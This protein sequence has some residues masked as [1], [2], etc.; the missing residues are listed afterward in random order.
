MCGAM[1]LL[2]HRSQMGRGWRSYSLVRGLVAVVRTA[3]NYRRALHPVL[4]SVRGKKNVAERGWRYKPAF[5]V[6]WYC[7]TER[8]ATGNEV[9]AHSEPEQQKPQLS[10]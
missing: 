9:Q 3:W 4:D 8:S 6:T 2:H 5:S 10:S 1:R 7:S